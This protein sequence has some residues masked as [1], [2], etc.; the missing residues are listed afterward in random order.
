MNDFVWIVEQM[1]VFVV[2][3]QNDLFVDCVDH[4]R[5]MDQIDQLVGCDFVYFEILLADLY[6]YFVVDENEYYMDYMGFGHYYRVII[7]VVVDYID[8]N[9]MSCMILAI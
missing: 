5:I 7:V 9:Y 6:K 4:N 3:V 8:V 2:D 1:W